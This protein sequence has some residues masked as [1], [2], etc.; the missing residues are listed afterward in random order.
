MDIIISWG[1]REKNNSHNLGGLV[2]VQLYSEEKI[3]QIL[4]IFLK[5]VLT[6][7]ETKVVKLT[8]L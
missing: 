2:R 4:L 7:C 6:H 1:I 3:L 8:I 5:T